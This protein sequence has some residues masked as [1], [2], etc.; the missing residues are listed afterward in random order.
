MLKHILQLIPFH[1]IYVEV[2][3]GSGRVLLNKKPSKIEVW[4]DNDRR[5]AN[6]FHVVVFKFEEFYEKVKGFG[7]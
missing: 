7:I 5:I 2:F 1:K 4:N 3:G 6:L